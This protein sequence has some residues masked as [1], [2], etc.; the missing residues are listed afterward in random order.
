MTEAETHPHVLPLGWEWARIGDILQPSGERT[1]PSGIEEIA[2]I[3]LEHIDKNTGK[4]LGHGQ[5]SE[6][7]SLKARFFKGDLLYGKLRPYLNKVYVADF[8]G[9]CSTD[10]L[11]FPNNRYISNKYLLFR[12]LKEDFVDYARQNS[13]GVQHPRVDFKKLANFRI[14]VA[15][16]IEQHRIVAKIEELFSH[17]DAGVEGLHKVKAQLKRYRQSV[18]KAA[19][20]GRLTEDW[21]KA[22][23]EVEP[24]SMLLEK[25]LDDRLTRWHIKQRLSKNKYRNPLNAKAL[26]I[27]LPDKWHIASLEQLTSALRVICYGILMPKE[28]VFNGIPYIRVK[29]FKQDKIDISGLKRTSPEIA[30]KY[31]RSSLKKGD[32]ILAIRGTYGRVAEVPEELDGSN[33]TQ[34]T[35]RLDINP[36]INRSYINFYL[37]SDYA[38]KYFKKVA[39]GVAVKGVNIADVKLCPIILP[40]VDEQEIIVSRIGSIF[41]IIDQ[42]DEDIKR[43]Y[44]YADQLYRSILKRAFEGKLVPQDPNDEPASVLLGRIIAEKAGQA[45]RTRGSKSDDI[46]QMRLIND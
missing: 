3:G 14:P 10:I 38:Q 18:L 6:V 28:N 12:F 5:S 29:D 35:A 2:Y 22:H 27:N 45:K 25:V 36:L 33:I 26:D 42:L 43:N 41:P 15:P 30:E 1:N 20:E 24:A 40:P 31:A 37:H 17:L 13:S 34:D 11:V 4:L 9:V 16:F 19:V 21:R 44:G 32:L 46:R 7:R 8:D 39:R 23:P